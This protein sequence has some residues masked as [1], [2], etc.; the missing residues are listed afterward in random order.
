MAWTISLRYVPEHDFVLTSY[1]DVILRDEK[2][3]ARWRREVSA[4]FRKIGKKPVDVIIDLRCLIVKPSAGAADGAQRAIIIEE[5]CRRTYRFGGDLATRTSVY[6]SAVLH[7]AH[8]NVY[9]TYD[10]AV[11]ALLHDRARDAEAPGAFVIKPGS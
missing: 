4:Q 7:G 8:A 1:T 2:D 10:D 11:R 9:A 6:T 3:A 5:F